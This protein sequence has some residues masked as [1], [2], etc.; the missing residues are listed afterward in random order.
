MKKTIKMTSMTQV[1]VFGLTLSLSQLAPA[2]ET[3]E[4]S[5]EEVRAAFQEC[6]EKV[7]WQK[8]EE[9]HRPQAPDEATRESMDACMK[10]KGIEL[11]KHRPGREGR[12]PRGGGAR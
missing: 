7:G 1:L 5:R 8:P 2:Q 10:E 11:P 3:T 12:P 4:K 9:G 6:A